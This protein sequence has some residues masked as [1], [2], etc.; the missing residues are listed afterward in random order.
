MIPLSHFLIVAACAVCHQRGGH[1]PEPQE[2]ADLDDVHRDDVAG[3]EP[4]FY[5]IFPLYG[6]Y[7]GAG[8]RV[9][10]PDGGSGRSGDWSGNFGGLVP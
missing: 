10:Y 1:V 3:G 4:E 5:R 9:L 8:V 6:G 2:C 7:G